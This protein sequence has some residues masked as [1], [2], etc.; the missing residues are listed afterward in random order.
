MNKQEQEFTIV[1]TAKEFLT[2]EQMLI[3][4]KDFVN[5][6]QGYETKCPEF[7]KGA[8]MELIPKFKK[9]V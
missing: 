6:L 1:I 8:K 2:N 5:R 4:A 9:N 3:A 7:L